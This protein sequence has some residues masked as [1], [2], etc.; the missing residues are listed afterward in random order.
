MMSRLLAVSNSK[1]ASAS[2]SSRTRSSKYFFSEVIAF[3]PNLL[4]DGFPELLH[5]LMANA[6]T[7]ILGKPDRI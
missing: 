3:D 4:L 7:P 5:S 1:R 6:S 2:S